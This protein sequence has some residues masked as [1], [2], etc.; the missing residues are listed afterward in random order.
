M[1][2]QQRPVVGWIG[3]GDQGAPIALAIAKAGYALHVWARSPASLAELSDLP[4]T[5][6][7]SAVAMAGFCDVVGLCLSEDKDNEEVLIS[8]GMLSALPRGSVVVNHGTGLPAAAA[9][10]ADKARPFGVSVVDAPV[11]GGRAGAEARQL[12]TIVG[13]ELHVV[14]RLRPL[15]DTFSKLVVHLG[16]VGSGQLGKLLNNT[17]LMAN[18]RNVEQ[19]LDIARA[20]GMDLRALVRVLRSGTGSS[21]ALEVLGNAVRVDNAAHLS[22]LQLIDNGAV[23]GGGRGAAGGVEGFG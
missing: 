8:G 14:E 23:C 11:S 4:R 10:M 17:L 6:H 16:P 15:F 7:E 19:T 18:Q 20:A 22:A 13:G 2:E 12:T 5:V 9:A 21:V 1:S 3:L